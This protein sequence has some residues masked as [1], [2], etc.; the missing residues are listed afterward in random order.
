MRLQG[1][2]YIV[3]LPAALNHG[4]TIRYFPFSDFISRIHTRAQR[5]IHTTRQKNKQINEQTN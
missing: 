4:Q 3:Y 2:L 1:Q 5:V